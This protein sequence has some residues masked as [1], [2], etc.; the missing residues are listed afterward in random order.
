[1]GRREWIIVA[2]VLAAAALGVLTVKLKGSATLSG[3]GSRAHGAGKVINSAL[4]RG[5]ANATPVT[6]ADAA[7]VYE[8]WQAPR[9]QMAQVL[10]PN[11]SLHRRP[12]YIGENRHSVMQGGWDQWYYDPPSEVYW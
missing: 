3:Y 9:W 10:R 1:V 4:R 11:H 8:T 12:G 5:L 2:A 6:A 7:Q